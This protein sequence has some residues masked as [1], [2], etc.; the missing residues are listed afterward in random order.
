MRAGGWRALVLLVDLAVV[1]LAVLLAFEVRFA[2]RPPAYNLDA[3]LHLAPWIS[4]VALALLASFDLYEERWIPPAELRQ[5]LTPTVFLLAAITVVISYLLANLGFPRSVLVISI[6]FWWPMLY[7][8][9]R[10]WLHWHWEAVPTRILWV[11]SSPSAE[12]LEAVLHLGYAPTVAVVDPEDFSPGR[13]VDVVVIGEAVPDRV[14]IAVFLDCLERRIPCL[15]RPSLYDGLVA[16]AHLTMAGPIPL[17]SLKPVEIPWI[18]R[19]VKRL[20]DLVASAVLMVLLSPVGLAIALA[21]LLDDGPPVFYRQ[22]RVRLGGQRFLLWKFRTLERD[23]EAKRGVGLTPPDA[24]GATRVG[25]I[26]RRTHLDELPQLWN[27]LRGEMSLVGPRPERPRFVEAFSQ[28][29][30]GYG[31]RHHAP[32]G[33]TG[34]AQVLGHYF[35]S[36]EEKLHMDLTYLR[37]HTFW[38]DLKILIRTVSHLWH[39]PPD[40]PS[41]KSAP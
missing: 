3:Y 29:Y 16:Q 38:Q 8:W 26:L 14:K 7:A 15:W 11:G 39:R 21:I 6:A 19:W 24:P 40:P 20:F 35:S 27:V 23:H 12:E 4:L 31:L 34:L 13:P 25:R 33:V 36:P 28:R 32:P 1:H 10:V 22:E 2:G 41:A 5:R 37:S 9:R 17:L 30:P 18:H